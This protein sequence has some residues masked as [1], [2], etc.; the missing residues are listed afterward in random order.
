MHI[1][2]ANQR[3][4]ISRMGMESSFLQIRRDVE[5]PNVVYVRRN[6]HMRKLT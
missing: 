4:A 6:R 3:K 5:Q 1:L 2:S